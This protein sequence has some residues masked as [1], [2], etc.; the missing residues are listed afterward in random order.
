MGDLDQFAF[1]DCFLQRCG[2]LCEQ[3]IRQ[4]SELQQLG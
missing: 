2:I 3:E 1:C 4:F